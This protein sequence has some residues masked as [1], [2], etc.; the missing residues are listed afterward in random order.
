MSCAAGSLLQRKYKACL[1]TEASFF[2]VHL[3][4]KRDSYL[5]QH[6]AHPNYEM[7]YQQS[8]INAVL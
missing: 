1:H 2:F 8:G 6:F 5:I 7:L 4:N 3:M